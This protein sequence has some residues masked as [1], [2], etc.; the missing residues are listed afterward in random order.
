MDNLDTLKKLVSTLR[1]FLFSIF[2]G[3]DCRDPPGLQLRWWAKRLIKLYYIY[4][5]SEVAIFNHQ[6]IVR[7]NYTKVICN[8]SQT[9]FN[10]KDS[11]RIGSTHHNLTGV[12]SRRILLSDRVRSGSLETGSKKLSIF[13]ITKFSCN[14]SYKMDPRQCL[15]PIHWSLVTECDDLKHC[16]TSVSLITVWSYPTIQDV[17][18]TRPQF[19]LTNI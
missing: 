1:T 8:I 12:A 2:I 17:F 13:L 3:L 4:K 11:T 9:W 19:K 18:Y 6:L 16:I 5:Y 10:W 7:I 14:F 15:F